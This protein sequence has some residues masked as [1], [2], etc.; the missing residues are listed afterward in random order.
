MI[1]NGNTFFPNDTVYRGAV[2]GTKVAT[3]DIGKVVDANA[4]E[5]RIKVAWN[6]GTEEWVRPEDLLPYGPPR[7]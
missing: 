4:E 2:F 5:N 3:Q 7:S 6:D 1:K